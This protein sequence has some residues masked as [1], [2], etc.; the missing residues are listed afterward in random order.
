MEEHL[1]E[2]FSGELDLPSCQAESTIF[3]YYVSDEGEWEHWDK[4]VN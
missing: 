2:N 4:K 3:E 1:R